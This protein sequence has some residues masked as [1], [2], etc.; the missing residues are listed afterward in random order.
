MKTDIVIRQ[1]FKNY[2][3]TMQLDSIDPI[4]QGTSL[5]Q[6]FKVIVQQKPYFVRILP[7]T[8]LLADR[9]KEAL[10]TRLVYQYQLTADLLYHN[11]DFSVFI[12][13]YL[14]G[15]NLC[16]SNIEN[17]QTLH[18]VIKT[19]K[20]LH[21]IPCNKIP[22]AMDPYQR[23]QY[24][25]KF[26]PPQLTRELINNPLLQ[27]RISKIHK[28]LQ[29]HTQLCLVHNDLNMNNIYL[30]DD[31]RLVFL[32]W[33]DGGVGDCFLDIS[34]F[35]MLLDYSQ[36]NNLL[37]EYFAESARQHQAKLHLTCAL[38]LVVFAAWALQQ[39]SQK[40][41]I[42]DHVESLKEIQTKTRLPSFYGLVTQLKNHQFDYNNLINLQHFYEICLHEFMHT[43]ATNS[44]KQYL[45]ELT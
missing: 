24:Y 6:N 35:A 1:A 23:I 14:V 26:V 33:T 37:N 41:T 34:M 36:R 38:F 22:V 4:Q 18:Q 7:Q 3:N 9:Q 32:D 11:E 8:Q 43:T 25:T 12:M 10:L 13:E 31:Q 2:L 42:I 30:S 20:R 44:F 16:L 40:N 28:A 29:A 17:A 19:M 21:Q 39:I 15:K 45:Q 27:N 5:A